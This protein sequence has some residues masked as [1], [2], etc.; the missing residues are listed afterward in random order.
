VPPT[1]MIILAITLPS[2]RNRVSF[3]SRNIERN[4]SGEEKVITDISTN[5]VDLGAQEALLVVEEWVKKAKLNGFVGEGESGY[6]PKG[7]NPSNWN[8]LYN[9]PIKDTN[10]KTEQ[11]PQV[12]VPHDEDDDDEDLLSLLSFNYKKYKTAQ[13][14][15]GYFNGD[16][17]DTAADILGTTSVEASQIK[18]M[19]GRANEAIDLVN[20]FDSSLLGNISFIFNFA[21][22]GAYGVYLSALDRAIKT[23]ALQKKLEQ[24]GYSV[25]TTDQGLTAYPKD[26]G[27]KP[28]GE[29]QA[30]IDSIYKD[31]E[32]KGGTAFGI[33]MNAV[34]DA[35]K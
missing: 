21:K 3:I 1:E 22:S 10:K 4:I 5:G 11:P 24:I 19:F 35:S 23:K 29:I 8:F 27:N 33:N 25:D 14:F 2:G 20:K 6:I 18:S 12:D 32:S 17:P 34:L 16:I 15:E 26:G 13:D 28:T 9:T 30:D 31:L 7:A